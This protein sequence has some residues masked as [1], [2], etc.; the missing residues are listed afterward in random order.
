MLLSEGLIDIFLKNRK[1]SKK[2]SII[3]LIS[4]STR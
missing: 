2:K 4:R 3:A 1:C